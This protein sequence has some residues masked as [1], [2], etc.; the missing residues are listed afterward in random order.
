MENSFFDCITKISFNQKY[1][2]LPLHGKFPMKEKMLIVVGPP[3]SGWITLFQ[4]MKTN[5]DLH[6]SSEKVT[7]IICLAT[8][9][10]KNLHHIETSQFL[11]LQVNFLVSIIYEFLLKVISEQTIIT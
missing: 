1:Y 6:F 7:A 8:V 2:Q 4:G 5:I 9:S 11:A 10:S 3:D